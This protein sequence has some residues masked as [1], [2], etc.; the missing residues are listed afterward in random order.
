[1]Q[2]RDVTVGPTHARFESK[3]ASF[4]P[5]SDAISHCHSKAGQFKFPTRWTR[6]L[7]RSW[8]SSRLLPWASPQIYG[9]IRQTLWCSRLVI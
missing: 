2:V 6:R 3:F 9:L 1:M 7:R 4:S 8:Q 5:A